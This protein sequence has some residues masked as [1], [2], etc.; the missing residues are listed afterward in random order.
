MPFA[1]PSQ[2]APARRSRRASW[3]RGSLAFLL[4]LTLA[5]AITPGLLAISRQAETPAAQEHAAPAPAGA[6]QEPAAAAPHGAAGEGEHAEGALPPIARLFN[7]AVLVGLLV[8]FLR[9]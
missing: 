6:P 7:F 2:A 4:T 3:R 9:T 1:S 8:Y 5:A